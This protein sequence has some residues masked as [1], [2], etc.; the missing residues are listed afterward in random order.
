M[1][2]DCLAGPNLE[3]SMIPR[4][5]S[6][7]TAYA[8]AFILMTAAVRAEDTIVIGFGGG[9]TGSLAF[10]DGLARNGAQ[11]AV[12][13]INAAGGIAGRYKIDFQVKDVRSEASAS[14]AAGREF[15]AA[16]AKVLVAPCDLDTAVAF[17]QSAQQAGV[18]IVAPCASTPTLAA[19]VGDFMFQIYPA[20][21][22]QAAA[23]AKFAREQGYGRA[24]ILQSPDTP[25]T[26]K[27]PA[28]FAAAFEKMGGTV[29]GKGSYAAAQQDFGDVVTDIKNLEPKPDVIMT[30]AYEPEFPI[31]ISQLR[32]AG[33]DTPVLGSDA[34][35]SP[36]TLALGDVAEG[37]VYTSAAYPASDG[38]LEKFYR[39]YVAKF[40]G[41]P[42]DVAPYAATAYEAVKLI[43]AAIARAGSTD[44]AAIRDAL[45]GIDDFPGVTGSRMTLVGANRVALRDVA[46]IRVEKGAKALI[47][48]LRPDPADVPAPQ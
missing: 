39:D 34:L 8:F 19:A 22:L 40:G 21:N 45:D 48:M 5:L 32:A 41:D 15:V 1:S 12:D 37:V 16:G 17:S 9:L 38:Q 7:A 42:Q 43:E 18:L 23:L 14:A 31:F 11:M 35:D 2:Y 25:Y 46:L 36:T 27:L 10:Y 6:S 24:Y 28:Y 47:K 13:E 3:A 33:I 4:L 44:G 20:D 29:A 30:A 26:E